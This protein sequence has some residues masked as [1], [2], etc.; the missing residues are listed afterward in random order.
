[1][2]AAA[3]M[4]ENA[5]KIL[6]VEDETHL[7]M[8][9]KLNLE[10]EGFAVDVAATAREAGERLL[11]VQMY[12]AIVLDVMLPDMNGFELCKRLRSAGNFVPVVMLT[13]RSAPDDRVRGLEAGADDYMVKPFDLGELLARLRSMLR[14]RK[15]E[16]NQQTGS[17]AQ[18][19]FGD[20][21][22]NFDTLEAFVRDVPIKLT[23][24]EFDLLR[25]FADNTG[26]VLGRDELLENVWKLRNYMNTRTVD[27]FLSRLRRHF[28]EDPAEPKHFVSVRGA[29]Y[30]FLR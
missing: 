1:M 25:Y 2:Y 10:L 13:A 19:S 23:R 14:R 7:A 12:D 15:W 5:Q 28:E 21:R 17:S 9:L 6:L 22:V 18:L 27:N 3:S 20:A 11:Q 30:K 16:N 4:N 29:G 24:L 26:R 8:G